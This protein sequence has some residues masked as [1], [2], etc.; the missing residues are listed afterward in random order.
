MPEAT[1]ADNVGAIDVTAIE[2]PTEAVGTGA[3]GTDEDDEEEEDEVLLAVLCF[4]SIC[5]ISTS[6]SLM[7]VAIN[8]WACL[9]AS[10]EPFIVIDRSP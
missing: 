8:E 10:S 4:G 2:L 3:D 7:R 5:K 9:V 6:G 1:T